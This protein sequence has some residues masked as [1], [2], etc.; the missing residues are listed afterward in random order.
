MKSEKEE[1]DKK[2]GNLA[3]FFFIVLK[4]EPTAKGCELTNE[5]RAEPTAGQNL[6]PLNL[7]PFKPLNSCTLELLNILNLSNS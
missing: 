7:K 2:E 6:E 3:A 5:T 1:Y 4:T